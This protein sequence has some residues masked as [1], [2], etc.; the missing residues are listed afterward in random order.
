MKKF[1]IINP[2]GLGDVLFTTPV[3]NAIKE[4]FP[5]SFLS[6][7]CNDRVKDILK[8]N[9]KVD[10]VFAL[11][12]GDLKKIYRK[13]RLEAIKKFFDLALSIRKEKF[14]V[15]FDF[16]LDHRYGL[17]TKILGIKK[18]IGLN[19]RNR[20]RFLTDK[21]DI[22]GYANKHIIEYNL[23]LL[24]FIG[25][26]PKKKQMSLYV[27][28]SDKIK[29]RI[30]LQTY[31]IKDDDLIIAIAPGAGV[32]W[33]KDASL[34]HWPAIKFAQLADKL[35]EELGAKILIL[36]DESEKS[37]S[38]TISYSMKNKPADLVGKTTLEE[39]F[40]I[41]ENVRIL[42]TNDGGPLHIAVA[43]G[44]KTVSIFG[45]VDDLVYGP[46]PL[47]SKHIVIKKDLACRPCYKKFR[48]PPCPMDRECMNA[49]GVDEVYAEVSRLL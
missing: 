17:L 25:V 9:P 45:P 40:A 44:V 34:K 11:S 41:I 3:I 39:L 7:W 6:Y 19:Y 36:G 13:S 35:I 1:L 42:V 14:D 18:R 22:D 21:I 43:L 46:Y 23:D 20:G 10:K 15:T 30:I 48:M 16:S 24:K 27:P 2:F 8:N 33:G 29:S 28:A 5:D 26:E 38:E 32:S 47:S 12:R 4:N 49:I 37:I 31:Q